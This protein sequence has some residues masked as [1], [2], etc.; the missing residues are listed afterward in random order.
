MG[1][2][3]TFL[4]SLLGPIFTSVSQRFFIS[5]IIVVSLITLTGFLTSGLNGFLARNVFSPDSNLIYAGIF[6]PSNFT[7]CLGLIIDA[8]LLRAGYDFAINK[9]NLLK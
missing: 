3:L 2:L 1:W 5:G 8:M 9:L 6:L 4:G 7:T